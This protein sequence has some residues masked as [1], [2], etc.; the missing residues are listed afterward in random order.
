MWAIALLNEGT[1]EVLRVSQLE[2]C[3]YALRGCI[4]LGFT[5]GILPPWV[6]CSVT[7]IVVPPL[8]THSDNI[9]PVAQPVCAAVAAASVSALG[10]TYRA[11]LSQQPETSV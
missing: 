4:S 2:L 10:S 7:L 8:H 3:N 1:H 6:A 9:V 11:C 5:R